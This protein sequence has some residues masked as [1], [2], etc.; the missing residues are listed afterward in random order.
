M[1][2][3]TPGDSISAWDSVG[4]DQEVGLSHDIFNSFTDHSDAQPELKTT[5]LYYV[6]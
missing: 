4:M 2:E 6:L 1:T 3:P 5:E